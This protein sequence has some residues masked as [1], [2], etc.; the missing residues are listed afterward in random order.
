MMIPSIVFGYAFGE[1][2]SAVA[3]TA[4]QKAVHACSAKNFPPPFTKRRTKQRLSIVGVLLVGHRI[5]RSTLRQGYPL[6]ALEHAAT[7]P[8][9]DLIAH[10]A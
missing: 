4:T 5:A 7:Q 6:V 1:Y 9:D 2:K 8:I 3:Y 10:D